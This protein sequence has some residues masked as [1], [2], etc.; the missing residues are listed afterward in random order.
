MNS[1]KAVFLSECSPANRWWQRIHHQI[2]LF[3]VAAAFLAGST[4][5]FGLGGSY[6]GLLVDPSITYPNGEILVA[7]QNGHLWRHVF[8]DEE[9]GPT[10]QVTDVAF[11]VP[12]CT[13]ALDNG[14]TFP[15]NFPGDFKPV[16]QLSIIQR[17]AVATAESGDITLSNNPISVANTSDGAYSVAGGYANQNSPISVVNDSTNK[18][19][20]TLNYP[21]QFCQAVAIGDDNQTVVAALGTLGQQA[22]IVHLFTLSSGTLTDTGTSVALGSSSYSVEKLRV[23]AGSKSAVAMVV[24]NN[25][26]TELI[27]FTLPGLVVTGT[28]TLA[29]ANGCGLAIK[30]DGTEVFARSGQASVP[31]TIEGFTFNGTTGAFGSTT[32][33]LTINP[34]SAFS[35]SG[36]PGLDSLAVTPDGT[37]LVAAE[38]N[39]DNI[40]SGPRVSYWNSS[41]GTFVSALTGLG[42]IPSSVAT[43]TGP[44]VTVPPVKATVTLSG[45]TQ[46]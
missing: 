23:A 10:A 14:N 31:D 35:N 39:L 24:T 7:D 11:G 28:V 19:I 42:G 18:Q 36:F 41:T 20:Q 32:A 13:V 3:L 12:T 22:N 27:S 25:S 40:L 33:V 5:A 2:A 46:A 38:Q 6:L 44:A 34:I 1:V 26:T 15:L 16:T 43:A 45:L 21:G 29:K 17:E 30:P 9:L 4:H 37:E 8:T